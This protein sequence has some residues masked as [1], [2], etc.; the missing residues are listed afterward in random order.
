MVAR[1][2]RRSRARMIALL[3]VVVAVGAGFAGTMPAAGAQSRQV[4]GTKHVAKRAQVTIG[5]ISNG[6]TPTVDQTIET[7]VSEATA[8][9]INQYGGGLGGRPIPGEVPHRA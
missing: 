7:P 5:V 9:W 3:A 8:K 4:L 2:W 6:K 1:G